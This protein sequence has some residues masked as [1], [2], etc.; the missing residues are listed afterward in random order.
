M[1]KRR[2]TILVVFLALIL[3]MG[4][5]AAVLGTH[6]MRS[7][8]IYTQKIEAG[9]RYLEAGDYDNAI[10]MY[11]QAI[12]S[13]S[14]NEQGYVKLATAY[15]NQG[16]IELAVS[17]LEEGY[18]KTGSERLKKMLA[19]YRSYDS[20]DSGARKELAL[21]KTMLGTLGRSKYADYVNRDEIDS[22][23]SGPNGEVII[24][25]KGIP[26]DLVYRNTT[27]L[28]GTVIGGKVQD[29]A[30]PDEIIFDD[31]TGLLGTTGTVYLEQLKTLEFNELEV[32]EGG[33]TGYQLR[34]VYLG[35]TIM[36]PC[37]RDGTIATD[38]TGVMKTSASL[39]GSDNSDQEDQEQDGIKLWGRIEDA[40]TGR[41]IEGV[42]VYIY[43]SGR[44]N[45]EPVA[46]VETDENGEYS[47]Y[48]D[49]GFY[50]AVLE[51]DGYVSTEKDVHVGSYYAESEEDFV[52]SEESSDEIRIVL[53]WDSPACDLD[54]YL[55]SGDDWMMFRNKEITRDGK[56]A[57][58][59]DRDARSGH[60]V[61]TTTIYDMEGSYEF[62]VYD[63]L[64]SGEL[65]N[66]G[67]TVTIYVPGQSPQVVSVPS[68]GGNLWTVC[69][70]N[71]GVL[72]ITNSMSQVQ[73]SY[74]AK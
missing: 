25:L 74:G 16:N 73:G 46:T 59:L 6:T 61:E 5:A 43:E 35:N 34:M 36:V 17:A 69:E 52:M 54:S 38:S 29:N 42:T 56:L 8:K 67:A 18:K 23:R 37:D 12:R 7:H 10:L 64:Q 39:N 48:V 72:S 24:R 60:G 55:V 71:A 30:Y 62:M 3:A 40:Q 26:A 28:P 33:E 1:D 51:R 31:L 65:Q 11:Q 20:S 21:N 57:A 19:V 14:S 47:V 44:R 22:S 70:I 2:R 13:D 41:G 63:Y 32:I 4:S 58:S 9:D 50:V 66:S 45:E 49:E 53:E 27:N 15:I 68:D